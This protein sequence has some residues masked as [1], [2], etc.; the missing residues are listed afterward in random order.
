MFTVRQFKNQ[1]LMSIQYKTGEK[2]QEV[3]KNISTEVNEMKTN[4][5]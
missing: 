5:K 1:K 3:V 4:T 2:N